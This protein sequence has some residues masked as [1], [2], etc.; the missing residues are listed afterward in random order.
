MLPA[1]SECEQ[2]GVTLGLYVITMNMSVYQ[3]TDSLEYNVTPPVRS[4]LRKAMSNEKDAKKNN[5]KKLKKQ[6]KRQEPFKH[7]Y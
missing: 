7:D 3:A 1:T 4:T 5:N 6:N 2:L